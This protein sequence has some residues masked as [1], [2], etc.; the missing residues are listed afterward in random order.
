MYQVLYCSSGGSTKKVADAI[1]Q[2]LGVKAADVNGATLDPA[3][4]VVFLGSG[5]YGGLPGK[6]MMEFMAANDF[7][8]RKV[9]F[10]GTCW[11]LRLNAKREAWGT[12]EAMEKKG[13]TVLGSYH[14]RGKTFYVFNRGHPDRD[15]VDGAK[16][17]AREMAK[18][19]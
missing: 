3:A 8:G 14:C 9:A 11:F 2:E 1:A 5:R 13:A 17:F 19:G 10:F 18:L 4:K 16:K 12:T 7:N 6:A 15:E